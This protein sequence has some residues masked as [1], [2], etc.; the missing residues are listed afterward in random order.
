M[1]SMQHRSQAQPRDP[2]RTLRRLHSREEIRGILPTTTRSILIR[3]KTTRSRRSRRR[4]SH[5]LLPRQPLPVLPR[6]RTKAK[7]KAR[8]KAKACLVSL[9]NL[10]EGVRFRDVVCGED[11]VE[12]CICGNEGGVRSVCWQ[13]LVHSLATCIFGYARDVHNAAWVF[14]IRS[15]AHS[16]NVDMFLRLLLSYVL[17]RYCS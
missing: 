17:F 6:P 13:I 3:R 2:L 8:A 14:C 10:G 4:R 9:N 16:W 11:G 15:V 5:K 1:T 12:E 7:I